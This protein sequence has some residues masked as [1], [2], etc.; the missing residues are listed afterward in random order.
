VL[1]PW[2]AGR[3]NEGRGEFDEGGVA[4]FV[5]MVLSLFRAG[6][7]VLDPSQNPGFPSFTLKRFF[8]SFVDAVAPKRA[9]AFD[10]L[11]PAETLFVEIGRNV[12]HGIG[13]QAL[14]AV[15]LGAAARYP[16]AAQCGQRPASSMVRRSRLK[17]LAAACARALAAIS[18]PSI[19]VTSPQPVQIRNWLAWL[20]SG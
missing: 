11:D 14:A 13:G 9:Q 15:L 8:L 17:P 10:Q 12:E 16:R 20:S 7:V 4:I 2:R 3:E 5:D 19:S 1:F 18:L 6:A